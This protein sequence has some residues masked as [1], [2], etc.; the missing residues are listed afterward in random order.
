MNEELLMNVYY[1]IKNRTKIS[2]LTGFKNLDS[3]IQLQQKGALILIGGRPCM[4]KTAF[5]LSIITNIA[6]KQEK[7]L[8][9][10][11]EYCKENTIKRLLLLTS[12]IEL[13]RFYNNKLDNDDY[14]KIEKSIE[15]IKNWNLK[16]FDDAAI[17][18]NEIAKCIIEQKPKFVFIEDIDSMKLISNKLDNKSIF[19]HLQKLAKENECII[20]ATTPLT[21]DTEERED[22]RP[23]LSDL[24]EFKNIKYSDVVLLLYRDAYYGVS[25]SKKDKSPNSEIIIAKN[26]YG[27]IGSAGIEFD[28]NN[29]KFY[30]KE[31][32]FYFDF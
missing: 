11:S 20:F 26:R 16:F 8:L 19:F 13:K 5:V 18:Y 21:W 24:V 31:S 15:E 25:R 23:K 3:I 17:E 7:I 4:G 28:T 30:E 1:G 6:P 9:F 29:V 32:P 27:S 14:N 12:G 2:L 10:T 22:H